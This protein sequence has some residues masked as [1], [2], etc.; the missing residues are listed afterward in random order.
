VRIH[1]HS[2]AMLCRLNAT[3]YTKFGLRDKLVPPAAF[4]ARRA[5]PP[6]GIDQE[7]A[8]LDRESTLWM[9]Y[10]NCSRPSD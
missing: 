8:A 5:A 6:A 7:A 9:R 4:F 2:V 1:D 3:S 10:P